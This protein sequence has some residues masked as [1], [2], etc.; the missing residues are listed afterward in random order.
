MIVRPGLNS[1]S[2]TRCGLYPF[3]LILLS[4]MRY[5]S[6]F[7]MILRFE[8]YFRQAIPAS[9]I[10]W[11]GLPHELLHYIPAKALGLSVILEPGL[12]L[13]QRDA[14]LWKTLIAYL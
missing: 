12:T 10:F 7:G 6:L 9:W 3:G 1:F 13:I 2:Y 14:P 5:T 4:D 8:E 11:L